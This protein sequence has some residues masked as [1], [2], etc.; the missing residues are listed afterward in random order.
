MKIF[1]LLQWLPDFFD[2]RCFLQFDLLYITA[3]DEFPTAAGYIPLL[4]ML[5]T[6][7]NGEFSEIPYEDLLSNKIQN[8]FSG[9]CRNKNL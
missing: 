8:S 4:I 2:T 5:V 7:H 6:G 9:Q 1:C 3:F